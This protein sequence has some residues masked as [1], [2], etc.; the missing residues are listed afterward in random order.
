MTQNDISINELPFS[1][2]LI[3]F[4]HPKY[5]DFRSVGHHQFFHFHNTESSAFG[6]STAEI[7]SKYWS[8]WL[9]VAYIWRCGWFSHWS[10]SWRHSGFA[11]PSSLCFAAGFRRS[12]NP[13]SFSWVRHENSRSSGQTF[14][15]P[16]A[17]RVQIPV[18]LWNIA[19]CANTVW[20]EPLARRSHLQLSAVLGLKDKPGFFQQQMAALP[21]LSFVH[22]AHLSVFLSGGSK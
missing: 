17:R 15:L 21:C 8:N 20:W 19:L 2:W 5:P 13:L 16:S 10:P 12:V 9:S 18:S 6:K 7:R 1:Q 22:T 11:I 14:L 4:F 3:F